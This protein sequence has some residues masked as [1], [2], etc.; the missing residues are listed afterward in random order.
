MKYIAMRVRH[1]EELQIHGKGYSYEL[2]MELMTGSVNLVMPDQHS[3]S[4][5]RV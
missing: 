3:N 1:F 2:K 4:S 5:T